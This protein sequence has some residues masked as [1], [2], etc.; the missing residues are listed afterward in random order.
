MEQVVRIHQPYLRFP[1]I[2]SAVDIQDLPSDQVIISIDLQDYRLILTVISYCIIFVGKST[3]SLVSLQEH[4]T[5][6]DSRVFLDSVPNIFDGVI[7]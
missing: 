6:V 2:Y 7:A 5:I 4:Q 3:D 1:G